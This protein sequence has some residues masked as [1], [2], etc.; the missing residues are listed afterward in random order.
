MF[1]NLSSIKMRHYAHTIRLLATRPTPE[2][3]IR[4][5]TLRIRGHPI[6]TRKWW[7]L[8]GSRKPSHSLT[9]SGTAHT[10][11]QN[12]LTA[13]CHSSKVYHQRLLPA[14]KSF[15]QS[16][17]ALTAMRTDVFCFKLGSWG[18]SSFM[19]GSSVFGY[20]SIHWI[21]LRITVDLIEGL[22]FSDPTHAITAT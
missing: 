11:T 2:H 4:R 8:G 5:N 3:G 18:S 1:V 7:K 6:C 15:R 20:S 13:T 10:L 22:V 16:F 14:R 19:C 12:I 21:L 9:T 17:F